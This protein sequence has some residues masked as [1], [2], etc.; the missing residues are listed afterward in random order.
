MSAE[1]QP[2][3]AEQLAEMRARFDEDGVVLARGLMRDRLPLLESAIQAV[4]DG[5]SRLAANYGDPDDP[6]S[7]FFSDYSNW[8][9]HKPL[10]EIIRLPQVANTVR[11]VL[12]SDTLR[13]FHDHVLVK[14]GRAKSTPWH[15]DQPYYLVDGP[16]NASVWITPDSVA[17]E[18]SLAYVRGSHKEPGLFMPAKFKSGEAMDPA[19]EG[20][21]DLTPE[22][23]DD[24]AERGILV[25]SMQPGDALIFDYRTVH[26]AL[27]NLSGKQRRALSIRYLGDDAHLTW[28]C[29]N[30]TPPFH[31]MGLKFAEGDPLPEAWFPRVA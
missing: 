3:S 14:K 7:S 17:A 10:E 9:R 25:F 16:K 24:L 27:P 20:F 23:L 18:N 8:R 12:G 30:P 29:V 13:I 15:H 21:R 22:V 26:G 4:V 11:S 1:S 31:R 19:V 28:N 6:D 5:P 2:Y